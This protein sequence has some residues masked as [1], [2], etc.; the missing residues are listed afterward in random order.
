MG[1][2]R[3]HNKRG[4]I[5]SLHIDCLMFKRLRAGLV[6]VFT[7]IIQT[8]TTFVQKC[9]ETVRRFDT[10]EKAMRYHSPDPNDANLT[11]PRA[12]DHAC[13]EVLRAYTRYSLMNERHQSSPH[14]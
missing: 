5:S 14:P 11:L 7:G 4:R 10:F 12:V 8:D 6:P 1:I 2:P 13:R 3:S 9:I